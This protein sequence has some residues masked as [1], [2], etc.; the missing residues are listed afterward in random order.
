MRTNTSLDIY[1]YWD[2][3]RGERPAPARG[4]IDPSRIR[5][6]L[7]DLFVLTD[8]GDEAPVFRLTGTRLYNLF[9][10]ELRD[11]PFTRIWQPDVADEAR[12]IANGVLQHQR[13]VIFDIVSERVDDHAA[14]AFEMLLLPLEAEPHFPPRLLGALVG[15]PPLT[16]FGQPFKPLTLIRSRLLDTSPQSLAA[17]RMSS[18][19]LRTVPY[20]YETR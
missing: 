9:G 2:E 20:H 10:R 18:A 15:D 3:L 7:P 17:H 16:D 13:P 6:L 1:A 5:H 14:Q 19:Y 4:E 11:T 12:R 8:L